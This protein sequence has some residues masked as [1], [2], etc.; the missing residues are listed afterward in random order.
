M[1]SLRCGLPRVLALGAVAV[2]LVTSCASTTTQ[3]QAAAPQ[4]TT[5]TTNILGGTRAGPDDG[6]PGT[7]GKLVFGIEGDPEGM[8]PVRY[9]LSESGHTVA[10]AVFDP[11]FAL[12]ASGTAVPYL[13]KGATKSEDLLTWTIELPT[14]V[15][16]H[17]GTD[18]DATAVAADMKA[19]QSS[20]ITGL[21]FKIIS[22]IEAPDPTH[23]VFHMAKPLWNFPDFLVTQGGYVFSPKMIDDTTLVD[24]PIGTGP[25]KIDNHVKGESWSFKRNTSYW[26]AGLPH[27]DAIEFRPIPDRA[28]RLQGLN[29]GD[30][31][32]IHTNSPTQIA[33]L[34]K[35]DLKRVENANG[36]R[37]FIV[38]NTQ[39]APFDNLKARQALVAATDTKKWLNGTMAG[40][41]QPANSPYAPGQPGYLAE[42]GYPQFDQAKARDLIKQYTAETGQPMDFKL[43]VQGGIDTQAWAQEFVAQWAEV[44]VKAEVVPLPEIIGIAQIGA[45][46][47]QAGIYRLFG[48]PNPDSETHFLR[49]SSITTTGISLNFARFDDYRIEPALD[50]ALSTGDTA[51][52]TS[53]YETVNKVLAEQVPYV[54][55]GRST[56]V[57][58]AQPKV[59]GIYGAENGTIASLGPKTWIADLSITK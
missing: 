19:Y 55:L 44:G 21:A 5:P 9:A 20:I 30:L 52:R 25:F 33:E 3:T 47:Y 57:V 39:A 46:N 56:W 15:K 45:G 6:T 42:N 11:L 50:T 49:S 48:Q 18:M 26:R 8:D 4:S 36:P 10:S 16:F 29:S 12:D 35:T 34:R 27:L 31:D 51:R 43:T 59:N 53:N 54:W 28:A 40:I 38:L 13:A 7:T 17:D 58:A 14:G 41:E 2:A 1:R 24:K 37:D 23:V 32:V 22:S